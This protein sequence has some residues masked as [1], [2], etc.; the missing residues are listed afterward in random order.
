MLQCGFDF[1]SDKRPWRFAILKICILASSSAGNAMFLGT[2][3]TRILIDAGV[4]GREIR[5]RLTAIGE[6]VESLDAV[7][8]SHEH[9]DHVCGLLPV[10]RK[11]KARVFTTRLTAPLIE[12]GK[13]QPT[14]ECF[15]A[16]ETF[17]I[18][19]LEVSSFTI[20]HDAADPVGFTVRANGLKVGIVTDLGYIP[21]SVKVHLR[22]TDFLLME[23]NHDLEMLKVGPY[24]WSVKQRVMGRNGHLSNTMV[25]DYIVESMDCSVKTLVLAHLSEHNNHPAIA[26]LCAAEAIARRGLS[27]AL[28]VSEPRTL[29]PVWEF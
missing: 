20:P 3:H 24:P 9:G 23:S 4:C 13:F 22:D 27:T 26:N 28:M 17:P 1:I 11:S 6:S 25:S 12:W 19:D 8:I 10:L 18:G 29:S 5:D 21:E 7:L 16:G 14:L 2:Q 15:Q